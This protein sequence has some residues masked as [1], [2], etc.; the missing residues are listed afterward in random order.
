MLG[1]AY[2]NLNQNLKFFFEENAFENFACKMLSIFIQTSVLKAN[3]QL[4]HLC[5]L[6]VRTVMTHWLAV[7]SKASVNSSPPSAA[8]MH[9]VNWVSIGSD[10]GLSPIRRQAII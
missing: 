1:E 9:Q 8:Y 4:S 5:Q 7:G 2:L 6:I 3:I 10:N